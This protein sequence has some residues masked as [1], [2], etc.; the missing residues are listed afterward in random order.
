MNRK[1]G[2]QPGG[3]ATAKRASKEAL[4]KPEAAGRRPLHTS[5]LL[6]KVLQAICYLA[7]K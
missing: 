1:F 3:T 7:K 2:Q 4:L 6:T 5:F